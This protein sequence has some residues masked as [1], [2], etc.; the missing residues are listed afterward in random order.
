MLAKTDLPHGAEWGMWEEP[1]FFSSHAPTLQEV[2]G[3]VEWSQAWSK[4]EHGEAALT[5]RVAH[6]H[7]VW[8]S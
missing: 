3:G 5:P 2:G 6:D 8:N 1:L 7:S 4:R